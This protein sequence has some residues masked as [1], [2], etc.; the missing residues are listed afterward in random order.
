M[1]LWI[2]VSIFLLGILETSKKVGLAEILYTCSLVEYLGVFF[3][4]QNFEFWGLDMSFP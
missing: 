2:F 4:L 3:I 1:D